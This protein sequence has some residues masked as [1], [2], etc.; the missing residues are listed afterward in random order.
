[1][2]RLGVGARAGL[3]HTRGSQWWRAGDLPPHVGM[4]AVQWNPVQQG[5][6]WGSLR[7]C[8]MIPK[9]HHRVKKSHVPDS[10]VAVA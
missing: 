1:M 3:A 6:R 8:G 7:G 9:I 5:T 2:A 4:A 10:Y